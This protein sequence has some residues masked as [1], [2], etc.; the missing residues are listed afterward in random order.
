MKVSAPGEVVAVHDLRRRRPARRQRLARPRGRRQAA[1]RVRR[2]GCA[3]C[4]PPAALVG[5]GRWRRV[6]GHPADRRRRRRPSSS[7]PRCA[8][9]LRHPMEIGSLT[10][11]VDAAVGIAVHPDHGSEAATLLQR[12]D[13]ATHAAKSQSHGRCSCSIRAW[14]PGRYAASAW[15]A[16]CAGRWTTATLEV[17][18]QPKVSLA[19]RA[20]V[21]VECL[22]RWEHPVHGAVIPED[23]VAVAEHTGQLGRLTDFVLREGL[24]RARDWADAGRPLPVAVNLSPRTLTRPRLPGPG[25]GL[26]AEYGIA[27]GLLTLEI[28]EDGVIGDAGPADA[29]AAPAA[30][31]WAS[32]CPSTTSAPA[33]RRCRTC[34]GCRSTRSRSTARSCRAWPPT[35]AIWRS[36]GPSS[37]WPGTS[38][39]RWSP[40]ASRASGP[41]RC[42]PRWA[43][44]SGQGFLFSRP[45]PYDRLE[46]WLGAQT[47]AEG[48]L[49]PGEIRGSGPCSNAP[50][51]V[52]HAGTRFDWRDR[53]CTLYRCRR[54]SVRHARRSSRPLSSVG[55]ASPW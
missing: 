45:L 32:G 13:V 54:A 5:P 12:A 38:A 43:A 41:C 34:G 33:T 8:T 27:A 15:P 16:T 6:R 19:D 21:G 50:G 17:Y 9:S 28:T 31:R 36:C 20:I 40:R 48:T 39:C 51:G 11:D 55:R 52:Q 3:S 23:F 25:R 14:S 35:R 1:G 4:R 7:R 26:L 42:S 30:T 49:P 24:R 46:A 47:D 53:P 37:I 29:D 2:R 22:A 10:L 44:M 18:F